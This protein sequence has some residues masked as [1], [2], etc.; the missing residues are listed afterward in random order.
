MINIPPDVS[1]ITAATSEGAVENKLHKQIKEAVAVCKQYRRKLVQNWSVNIDYRRGKPFASQSD[2]DRIAIPVDW[3]LTKQKQSLLFSQVPE[4]RVNHPP[5]T[6][7]PEFVGWV[8]NYEQRIN[9]TSVSSGIETAMDELLPDCINASGI[10]IAMMC[11]EALTEDV[12]VPGIDLAAFPPD[13]AAEIEASGM[14]PDGTPLEMEIVPR[15]TDSRYTTR[16]IS[17]AD[18]LWPIDFTGSDFNDAPWIGRSGRITWAEAVARFKLDEADKEKYAGTD[19]RN[20]LDRL[21]ADAE[22]DEAETYEVAFDEVFYKEHK[23]DPAA[24]SFDT[25]HH[26]VFLGDKKKPVIDEPWKGQQQDPETGLIVGSLKYPIQVLSLTYISDDAIPPSDSAIGRS[27]VNELNKSRTHMMLQRE[28]SRPVRWFDVNRVDPLIQQALMKGTWQHMIPVQGNG[29]KIIGE[30]SKA[31][32]PPENFHFDGI[33]KGDLSELWQVGQGEVGT[34]IETKAE[35]QAVQA[36]M[37]TRIGRERAKV[38]KFVCLIAEVLGGLLSIYEDPT[39]FGEGFKPSVS[40]TLSYSIL[41]DSTVL[42]DAAQRYKKLENF[43]NFAIKTGWLSPEVILKEMATLV[44]LDPAVAIVPPQPKPPAEPNVSLRLTGA[45]DMMNPL[46]LAFMDK[47]GLV[48]QPQQIEKM[49]YLIQL[50]MTPLPG[51]I[52]PTPQ[53][54]GEVGPDGKPVEPDPMSKVPIP[55]TPQPGADQLPPSSDP[56]PPEIGKAFPDLSAAERVNARVLER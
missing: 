8:H 30:V 48:P 56:P 49:K 26:L 35:V 25:I 53:Q 7:S 51:T 46:L 37:Q 13:V 19:Q 16:R 47:A 2:E 38:G 23:Y 44:G 54:P 12:E 43:Y 24:K 3:S 9:D 20:L 10:G 14:M 6:T 22:K 36:N 5:Q 1:P 42:L 31:A 41:A 33:I 55:I 40:R 27:Q 18:F 17:P 29:E 11:R 39:S 28:H 50:A 15:V 52:M 21:N 4:I 45:E 34:D 32:L